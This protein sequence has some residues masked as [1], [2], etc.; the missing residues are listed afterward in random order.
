MKDALLLVNCSHRRL[1]FNAFCQVAIAA[2][3]TL[4]ILYK[5]DRITTV[6]PDNCYPD[7]LKLFELMFRN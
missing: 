7:P 6:K 4:D 1:S 5:N 3:L 2:S